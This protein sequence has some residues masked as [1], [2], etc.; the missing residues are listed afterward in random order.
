[1]LER[2][3]DPTPAS[4]SAHGIASTGVGSVPCRVMANAYV[5]LAVSSQ[6][7]GVAAT[8]MFTSVGVTAP[9]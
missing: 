6:T 3:G 8:A 7:T 4:I 2:D 9:N 5:G 1:M